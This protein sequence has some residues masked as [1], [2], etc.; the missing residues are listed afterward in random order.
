[1]LKRLKFLSR[2]VDLNDPEKVKEFIASQ[3]YADGYKDNQI[4]A[5]SHF[6]KHY[7]I[8]WTNPFTLERKG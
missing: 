5:Y 2:N 8:Q 6:C 4:D 3:K 7:A 1:M